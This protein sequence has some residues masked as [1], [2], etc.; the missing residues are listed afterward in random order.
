[1][2]LKYEPVMQVLADTAKADTRFCGGTMTGT[3]GWVC[4]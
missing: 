3:S 1:M 2:S 4:W